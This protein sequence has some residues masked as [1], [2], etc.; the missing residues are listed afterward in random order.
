MPIPKIFT[1]DGGDT[2]MDKY[3]YLEFWSA[4]LEFR[5]LQAAAV[6][7]ISNSFFFSILSIYFVFRY[8]K[9]N[10]SE[11]FAYNLNDDNREDTEGVQW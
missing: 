2:I 7:S 5:P 9:L 4:I 1:P 10:G 6:F 8:M 11:G 3:N